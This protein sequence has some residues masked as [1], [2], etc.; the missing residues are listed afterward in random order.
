MVESKRKLCFLFQHEIRLVFLK[1]ARQIL[2]STIDL[3][4]MYAKYFIETTI[5]STRLDPTEQKR[6]EMHQLLLTKLGDVVV[7]PGKLT[8]SN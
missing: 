2:Q 4:Q 1:A 7:G 5:L 8:V 3:K 6:T